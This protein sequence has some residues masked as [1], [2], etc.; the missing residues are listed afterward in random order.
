MPLKKPQ[1]PEEV[2]VRRAYWREQNAKRERK[3]RTQEQ[4]DA[5]RI[6]MAARRAADPE[7]YRLQSLESARKRRAEN[8]EK[9]RAQC[10]K[11]Q[12]RHKPEILDRRRA[13]W[14]SDPAFRDQNNQA[15]KASYANEDPIVR[16]EKKV[17]RHAR[18]RERY[19]WTAL[20]HAAAYRAKK[21]NLE[22]TLTDEWAREQWTGFCAV[23]GLPFVVR[24]GGAPGPKF[25]SPSID[26]IAPKGGY[27]PANCRFVIWAVNALKHD[28][29]DA[30]VM[31]V[32]KS[33]YE[34]SRMKSGG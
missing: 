21:R 30:D 34:K 13:K 3:P 14:A 17:E 10:K 8:P 18:F 19:P 6:A 31:L 26:Q 23:S 1:T 24:V 9:N 16:A 12:E 32:V 7:K 11:Y 20:L 29:T 33:I 4:K 25:Y 22:F 15:R 5:Q 2:E 27:T 28:G